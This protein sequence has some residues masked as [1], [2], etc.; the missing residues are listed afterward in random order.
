M[1]KEIFVNGAA[2]EVKMDGNAVLVDVDAGDNAV[3]KIYK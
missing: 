2:V 3:I 1:A